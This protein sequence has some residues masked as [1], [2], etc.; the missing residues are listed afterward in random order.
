MPPSVANTQHQDDHRSVA[1]RLTLLIQAALGVGL[2]LFLWR[3]DWENFFLTAMVIGLT[4]IPALLAR[5][6]RIIVPPDF[7]FIAALFVFLSFFLGS[8]RDY[9]YKFWW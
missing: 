5:R 7:Q 2:A 1:M 6:Y 8:A 9:Y 4:L 3:G